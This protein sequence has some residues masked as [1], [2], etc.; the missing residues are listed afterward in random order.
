MPGSGRL[1]FNVGFVLLVWSGLD[2]CSAGVFLL[3]ALLVFFLSLVFLCLSVVFPLLFVTPCG[4][5]R[6]ATPTKEAPEGKTP[7]SE[8]S[9]RPRH[10]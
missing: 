10:S 2:P 4:S 1:F 3:Q 6:L 7:E 5:I 9:D 8:V